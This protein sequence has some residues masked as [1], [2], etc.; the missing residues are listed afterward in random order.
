MN[1]ENA[2][3]APTTKPKFGLLAYA[4]IAILAVFAG[5]WFLRD[6]LTVL[7]HHVGSVLDGTA[8]AWRATG[9]WRAD[10]WGWLEVHSWRPFLMV[11]AAIALFGLLMMRGMPPSRSRS[12]ID[13]IATTSAVMFVGAGVFYGAYTL[14]GNWHTA[15]TLVGLLGLLFLGARLKRV[16]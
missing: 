10:A 11:T 13:A 4:L 1:H 3:A 5:D 6:G 12:V 8:V 7:H 2:A 14:T 16:R 15:K 9:D